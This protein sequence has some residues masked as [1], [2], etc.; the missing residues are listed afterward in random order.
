MWADLAAEPVV[1]AAQ[2]Q[3]ALDPMPR[4]KMVA[5]NQVM[6]LQISPPTAVSA[7][8]LLPDHLTPAMISLFAPVVA[9]WIVSGG[10]NHLTCR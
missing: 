6:G 3:A 8:S 5:A 7:I 2:T 10:E 1:V 9:E 4:G